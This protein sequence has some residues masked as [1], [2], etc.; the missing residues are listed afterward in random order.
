MGQKN[1]KSTTTKIV[2]ALNTHSVPSELPIDFER[3]LSGDSING[4]SM[5]ISAAI[6]GYKT[7]EFFEFINRNRIPTLTLGNSESTLTIADRKFFFDL[8][9]KNTTLVNLTLTTDQFDFRD[10]RWLMSAMQDQLKLRSL[11]FYARSCGGDISPFVEMLGTNTFLEELTIDSL[12]CMMRDTALSL[13]Q[14]LEKNNT[15][16]KFT[17]NGTSFSE[18]FISKLSE[19]LKRNKG[20]THLKLSILDDRF[21]DAGALETLAEALKENQRLTSLDLSSNLLL[22][23]Q[24]SAITKLVKDN[25]RITA[26]ET[27]PAQTD[28][29]ELEEAINRNKLQVEAATL[30]DDVYSV[31]YPNMGQM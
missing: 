6:Q 2:R 13:Q 11:H 30:A 19:G 5:Q 7:E 14:T 18:L 15:L 28:A 29:Q 17:L 21:F 24:M 26:V 4:S 22:P 23:H 31:S 10:I 3:F 16:K 1:S 25:P 8:L 27:Y 20:I 9:G 12:S